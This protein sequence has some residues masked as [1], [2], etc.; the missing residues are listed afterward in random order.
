M[1]AGRIVH[2]CTHLVLLLL[3]LLGPHRVLVARQPEKVIGPLG[4]AHRELELGELSAQ[5]GGKGAGVE[6]ALRALGV[7]VRH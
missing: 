3:T 7:R 5:A 2:A 1:R 6:H 4:P